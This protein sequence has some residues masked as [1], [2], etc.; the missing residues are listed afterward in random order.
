M[1][2][3]FYRYFSHQKT[4]FLS[5]PIIFLLSG[6]H[7]C[8][9]FFSQWRFWCS[10]YCLRQPWSASSFRIHLTDLCNTV[11]GRLFRHSSSFAL[12]RPAQFLNHSARERDFAS[13]CGPCYHN[14]SRENRTSPQRNKTPD[15]TAVILHLSSVDPNKLSTQRRGTQL[16]T[17]TYC[18][19]L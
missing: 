3:P 11:P 19:C 13:C 9:R 10:F 14:L 16:I 8:G 17:R 15:T 6:Q 5:Y 18:C 4:A 12:V 1:G 7:L 2:K